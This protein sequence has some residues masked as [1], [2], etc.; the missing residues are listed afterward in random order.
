MR[1]TEHQ[2][3]Q[4]SPVEEITGNPPSYLVRRGLSIISLIFFLALAG[5]WF[6]RYPYIVPGRI[7]INTSNPPA[8]MMSRTTGRIESLF[9]T[10]GQQVREGDM[11]ALMESSASLQSVIDLA[12]LLTK[13]PVD[14]RPEGLNNELNKGFD[15]IE[16]LGELSGTY[17]EFKRSWYD[18]MNFIEVDAYGK[19]ISALRSEIDGIEQSIIQLNRSEELYLQKLKLARSKFKR[20]SLLYTKGVWS[21]AEYEEARQTLYTE[22]IALQQIRLDRSSKVI[23]KAARMQLMEDFVTAREEERRRLLSVMERYRR[24]LEGQTEEWFFKYLLVSPVDGK[25]TMHRFWGENQVAAEGDIIMTVVPEGEQTIRGRVMIDMM[26]SGKVKSGQK[27]LIKLDGFP[28]LEYG[29]VEGVTGEIS[30]AAT[31]DGYVV[32]VE[33]PDRLVTSYGLTPDFNQNMSGLAE[34]VTD[35]MRLMERL[36]FPFRYIIGKN[37]L[38]R[39]D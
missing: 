31:E 35:D 5:S 22:E 14:L 26:G 34:I 12:A 17:S 3:R 9:V 30:L 39:S 27:V 38:L 13:V 6:I 33:L 8:A 19:R 16:N 2:I 29:M 23:E 10:E 1:S 25:V 28:Y 7:I 20:D 15:S 18:Y 4:S 11:L 32:D 24:D 21:E 37:R 36:V